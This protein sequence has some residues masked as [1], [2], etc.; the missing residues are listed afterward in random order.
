MFYFQMIILGVTQVPLKDDQNRI[1]QHEWYVFKGS[2][3]TLP[4][5]GFF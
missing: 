4:F 2:F 5:L 1:L 3:P